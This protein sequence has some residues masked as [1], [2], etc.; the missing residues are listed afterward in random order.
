MYFST[1]TKVKSNSTKRVVQSD[2]DSM[3][4]PIIPYKETD[5]ITNDSLAKPFNG[6]INNINKIY[7]I[8]Y[9]KGINP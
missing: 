4:I 5:E 6:V 9:K 2:I 1:R 7:N 8:L 3:L